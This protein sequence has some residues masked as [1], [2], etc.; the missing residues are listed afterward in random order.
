M[1]ICIVYKQY[2]FSNFMRNAL[3]L[4]LINVFPLGTSCVN[5]QKTCITGWSKSVLYD[6]SVEDA[7]FQEMAKR[8]SYLQMRGGFRFF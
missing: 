4:Y 1:Y 8:E 2:I 5:R 3:F 6:F 7:M